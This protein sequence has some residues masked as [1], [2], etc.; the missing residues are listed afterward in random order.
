MDRRYI[1]CRRGTISV[2]PWR[3][4]SSS[5][6]KLYRAYI[7]I[8]RERLLGTPACNI[9]LA[10]G[11]LMNKKGMNLKTKENTAILASLALEEP[12]ASTQPSLPK[13][14]LHKW[15]PPEIVTFL[16]QK[17]KIRKIRHVVRKD[18]G[19]FRMSLTQKGFKR[20]FSNWHKSKEEAF[21][22]IMKKVAKL[23]TPDERPTGNA[24]A[25]SQQTCDVRG[26]TF[27]HQI[28]GLYRDG[29][30]M[31]QLFK[32][33]SEAWQ[34]YCRRQRCTYILWTAEEIDTVMQKYA[35]H[36]ILKLY[37]EVR[38]LVQQGDIARFFLL[39]M[40]GGLYADLDVFPNRDMYPQVTL[41]LCKMP[42]RSLKQQEEWEM[43]MV[44]ATSGNPIILKL[45]EHMII[46]TSRNQS[47]TYYESKACRYIYYTTGP[48]SVRKF[49]KHTPM[50]QMITFFSMCRPVKK[51]KWV[52]DAKGDVAGYAPT[53]KKYDVL[54]TFSMSYQ[55]QSRSEGIIL[56]Y[57]LAL[58]PPFPEIVL[59]RLKRKAPYDLK[60]RKA[61]TAGIHSVSRE[62][63]MQPSEGINNHWAIGPED[64]LLDITDEEGYQFLS[65][66]TETREN[67]AGQRASKKHGMTGKESRR[68]K[69]STPEVIGRLIRGC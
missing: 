52:L 9:E 3:R 24:L 46:Y 45:L 35:P 23:K 17:G 65:G 26:V 31:S 6:D 12:A 66:C 11:H 4:G 59:R 25:R 44:I 36:N 18:D 43:E 55:G 29:T 8:D 62:L 63:M 40:Y 32:L 58:L 39:Y 60:P 34:A 49:F 41:G 1:L 68:G 56:F 51:P 20:I 28:Y 30:E 61:E 37:K 47:M 2:G 21:E 53:L 7:T 38:Y 27:I 69:Y 16:S 15:S 13:W 22:F 14:A 10:V 19:K 67:A 50:E 57:G 42:S 5:S 54:S 48:K 64:K 33:S